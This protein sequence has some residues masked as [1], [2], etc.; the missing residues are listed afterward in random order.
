LG[1][2]TS[3]DTRGHAVPEGDCR[4]LATELLTK[5]YDLSL[6]KAVAG[7]LVENMSTGNTSITRPHQSEFVFVVAG[8]PGFFVITFCLAPSLRL[9]CA[10][11]GP[12]R[13]QYQDHV[14][15]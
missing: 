9:E 15:G 10:L 1:L 13:I 4:Y 2:V 7:A 3:S 12:P 8:P 14:Q 6:P 5:G 11:C